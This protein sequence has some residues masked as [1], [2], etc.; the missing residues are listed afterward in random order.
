MYLF[1]KSLTNIFEEGSFLV[2]LQP[3]FCANLLKIITFTGIFHGFWQKL[4]KNHPL[5]ESNSNALAPLKLLFA[6]RLIVN[7]F[8][9]DL[10]QLR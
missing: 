3:N 1:S 7:K 4:E 6:C 2:K 10:R 5:H 9:L 8:I